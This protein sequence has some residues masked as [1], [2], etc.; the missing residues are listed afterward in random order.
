MDVNFTYFSVSF[1]FKCLAFP[2]FKRTKILAEKEIHYLERIL[3]KFLDLQDRKCFSV[4]IL[5]HGV[6]SNS[7]QYISLCFLYY[8]YYFGQNKVIRIFIRF[9]IISDYTM[10]FENYLS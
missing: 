6:L 5:A 7:L 10:N 3:I 9:L 4:W 2:C 1:L 8:N